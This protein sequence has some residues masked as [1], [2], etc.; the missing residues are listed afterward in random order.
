MDRTSLSYSIYPLQYTTIAIVV[1]FA[2][3][4][5][6]AGGIGSFIAPIRLLVWVGVVVGSYALSLAVASLV[7]MTLLKLVQVGYDGVAMWAL[8]RFEGV[9]R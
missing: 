8:R 3:D 4:T 9:E 2:Y 5:L 6:L 1:P 7:D